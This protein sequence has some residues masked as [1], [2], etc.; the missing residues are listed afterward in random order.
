MTSLRMDLAGDLNATEVKHFDDSNLGAGIDWRDQGAVGAVKNQGGCGSCWAFCATA[1]T[2]AA[3]KIASGNLETLSEQQ[4]VDCVP[5]GC[6]GGWHG[7][8]L[9]YFMTTP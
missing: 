4:L 8:A 2:E 1:A 3:H 9:E 7:R 6:N 5:S